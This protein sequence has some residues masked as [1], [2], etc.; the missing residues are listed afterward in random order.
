MRATIRSETEAAR[1]AFFN[2]LPFE[3]LMQIHDSYAE[4]TREVSAELGVP[5]I[6]MHKRYRRHARPGH[7]TASD[8][9]HP[10]RLGHE[11]ETRLLYQW[12]RSTGIVR[13][14]RSSGRD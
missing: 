6:D 4:A 13:L 5:L 2:H 12:M 14:K 8:I 10:A 9:P 7:W 1:F 3:R 11:L